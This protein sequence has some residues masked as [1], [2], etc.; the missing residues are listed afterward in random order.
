MVVWKTDAHAPG[1]GTPPEFHPLD[2]E[3]LSF[4]RSRL[5][6]IRTSMYLLG[7]ALDPHNGYQQKYAGIILQELETIRQTLNR[8]EGGAL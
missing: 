3:L 2:L 6:V 8:Q 1:T 4:I 7:N 5:N